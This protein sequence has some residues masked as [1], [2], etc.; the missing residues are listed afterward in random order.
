MANEMIQN[1]AT[2]YAHTYYFSCT[3]T[4]RFLSFDENSE[5]NLHEFS[6]TTST[7]ITTKKSIFQVCIYYNEFLN[8]ILIIHLNPYVWFHEYR[9]FVLFKKCRTFRC[10]F[11][12]GFWCD[13]AFWDFSSQKCAVCVQC[14]TEVFHLP[15]NEST[16]KTME[17]FFEK[18][19]YRLEVK[20]FLLDD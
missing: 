6:L 7:L 19:R 2:A 1:E 10:R 8:E 16:R 14:V 20:L 5:W 11:S 18:K 9:H 12:D 17:V 13:C 4:N 15:T 3:A